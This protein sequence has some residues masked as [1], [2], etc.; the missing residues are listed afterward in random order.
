MMRDELLRRL[1]MLPPDADVFVDIGR[2]KV[3]IVEIIGIS[4][5]ADHNSIALKPHPGDLR[6]ALAALESTAHRTGSGRP[7]V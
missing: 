2:S 5:T 7:S 3:E 4:F 6:D 1:V